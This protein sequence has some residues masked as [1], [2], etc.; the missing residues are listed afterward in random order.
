MLNF[1]SY[2]WMFIYISAI[3]IVSCFINSEWL[4]YVIFV[5]LRSG[6]WQVIFRDLDSVSHT[7]AQLSMFLLTSSHEKGNRSSSEPHVLS[8]L[9]AN[10][11][12]RLRVPRHSCPYLRSQI[13]STHN[14][15]GQV[16]VYVSPRNRVAQLCTQAVRSTYWLRSK[17][18]VRSLKLL[19]DRR[20]VNQY[21]LVP[22]SLVGLVTRYYFL[23]E[24]CFLKF[25]V[26]FLW[27][28]FS[29]ESTGLQFAVQ[30]LKVRD[31]QNP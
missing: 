3:Y 23:S 7:R 28:A 5:F 14:L 15:E 18:E 21:D 27:G 30:S 22:S 16:P 10:G 13:W 17:F 25:A 1:L 29:D 8:R 12:W 19:Y 2:V 11:K 24:C 9:L 4:T 6:D 26:L 20:S 31:A